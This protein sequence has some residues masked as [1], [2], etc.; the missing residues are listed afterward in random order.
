MSSSNAGAGQERRPIRISRDDFGRMHVTQGDEHH[1]G[2]RPVR[3]FPLTDPERH[4]SLVDP[5]GTEVAVISDLKEL[6]RESRELIESE[7]EMAYFTP[8]VSAI[9]DVRSRFGITT[10]VLET[11]RGTRTAYVRDRSDIRTLTDGRIII[12]DVHGIKYEIGRI[13]EMDEK[14]RAFLEA[15][16]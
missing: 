1:E 13:D 2:V 3:A 16:S 9:R 6:D 4:I 8:R 15:E 5:E 10:W 14:S 11:D 7:L 12:T